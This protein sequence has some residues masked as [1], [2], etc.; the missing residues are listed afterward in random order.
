[1]LGLDE[2]NFGLFLLRV[3]ERGREEGEEV[4]GIFKKFF[5]DEL[6]DLREE[7]DLRKFKNG[8]LVGEIDR[9]SFAG[10]E[11]SFDWNELDGV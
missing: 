11:K 8:R 1:M 7:G 3:N 2:G 10:N 4:E 9:I 5:F 6:R